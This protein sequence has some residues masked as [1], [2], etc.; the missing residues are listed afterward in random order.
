MPP[1]AASGSPRCRSPSTS[2]AEVYATAGSDAKR[3]L[4]RSL[5]VRHVMNSRTLDFADEAA[6]P[7]VARAS[8]SSSTR[9]RARRSPASLRCL[10]AYGRFCEIGKIDIYQN[11]KLGLAPFQDNLSYHAI[12]LDRLLRERPEQVAV[13]ARGGDG[14]VRRRRLSA[15]AAHDIPRR[16]HR[17]GV[18]LHVA[19]QRTSARSWWRCAAPRPPTRTRDRPLHR[20]AGYLVTG[21]LGAARPTRRAVADR[22]GRRWRGPLVSE[23]GRVW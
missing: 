17:R 10:R 20:G 3:D 16:A 23:T 19:A 15:F 18:P 4:L 22:P 5:G 13:V 7:P 11:R 9:S 21:G 12:D 6:K 1:R 2:G 8:T 14:P